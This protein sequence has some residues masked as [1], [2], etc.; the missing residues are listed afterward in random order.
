MDKNVKTNCLFLWCST[1]YHSQ[2][3]PC[4]LWQ[5]KCLELCFSFLVYTPGTPG[6][7]WVSGSSNI[8]SIL[9]F[10]IKPHWKKITNTDPHWSHTYTHTPLPHRNYSFWIKWFR[11]RTSGCGFMLRLLF[12]SQQKPPNNDWRFT[13][14]QRPGPSGWVHWHTCTHPT[15]MSGHVIYTIAQSKG[16]GK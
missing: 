14:G 3:C 10:F 8:C 12:S 16:G 6:T 4:I 13:Q 7:P 5:I 2:K 11:Q 15:V 9:L 1:L